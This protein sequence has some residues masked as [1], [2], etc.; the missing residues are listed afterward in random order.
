MHLLSARLAGHREGVAARRAPRSFRPPWPGHLVPVLLSLVVAQALV[1]P[2]LAATA[3]AAPTYPVETAYAANGRFATTTEAVTDPAGGPQ[4]ELFRPADYAALGFLSPI[5]TWGDGTNASPGQYS[6]L[7]NHLASY[8]FT[9][10]APNLPNTGSGTEL[11]AAARYLIA[12]SGTSGS[13]FAGRLDV[14]HVAAVGHSQGAGGAVRAATNNATLIDTVVTFSLPNRFWVG[15]NADCPTRND[16]LYDPTRLSQPTFLAGTHGTLD[17]L[18]A[19]TST[20]QAFYNQ[21][22]GHA[23]LGLIQNSDGKKA[24][25]NTI[26]DSGDPAGFLGYVTAWLSAQLRGDAAAAAA[27]GGTGPELVSN[28]NWP[29]AAA[30]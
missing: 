14:G 24:D 7:L 21:V 28:G 19:S 13:V 17:S 22:P 3:A 4:Y 26:Q 30:K 25:H 10:I 29:G 20:E 23:V 27:F 18:I 9:V 1:R 16:C 5:V 11:A 8:G 12:Q 6:V 2:S 15:S